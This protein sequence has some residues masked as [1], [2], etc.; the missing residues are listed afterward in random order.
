MTEPSRVYHTNEL[1]PHPSGRYQSDMQRPQHTFPEQTT[2]LARTQDS[3]HDARDALYTHPSEHQARRHSELVLPSI[4]RDTRL[5]AQ[6]SF[7]DAHSQPKLPFALGEITNR[8]MPPE[9]VSSR[10]HLGTHEG[11]TQNKK[12]KIDDHQV[13]VYHSRE[14]GIL[15][16]IRNGDGHQKISERPAEA[17][18]E[19]DMPPLAADNRIVQ[20]P[21]RE[22]MSYAGGQGRV[23]IV[24]RQGFAE[25]Q[26][27]HRAPRE[28]F[29]VPLLNLEASRQP[30]SLSRSNLVQPV[31]DYES[32]TLVK[33]SK[34]AS[35]YHNVDD[36][37][38][39][40]R[41]APGIVAGDVQSP[42]GSYTA[43]ERSRRFEKA[44]R[45]M[46]S[47][48]RN[49]AIDDRQTREHQPGMR[50]DPGA[51]RLSCTHLQTAS[52][53]TY[54][55]ARFHPKV[56]VRDPEQC[57][58]RFVIDNPLQSRSIQQQP[59]FYGQSFRPG[60]QPFGNSGQYTQTN[61]ESQRINPFE[62]RPTQSVLRPAVDQWLG[63]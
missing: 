29:Q 45:E 63:F 3:S 49:L 27:N 11:P 46:R 44:G 22:A 60:D 4:E 56:R 26:S 37:S 18:Y 55:P 51:G 15:M 1:Q 17:V 48:F 12:R 62:R 23:Q 58:E 54:I 39:S 42:A 47:E 31:Y 13:F 7:I 35:S 53:E 57:R 52:P 5:E 61:L 21:P 24:D 34:T 41:H 14:R 16:P 32:P 6:K 20:L 33:A 36:L 43:M 9:F 30:Q 25:D 2:R 10:A 19:E 40:L 28:R 8:G 50:E 38:S 59:P